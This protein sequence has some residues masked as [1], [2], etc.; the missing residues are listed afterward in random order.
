MRLVLALISV[1]NIF[2]KSIEQSIPIVS[3]SQKVCNTLF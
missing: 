3:Y 1:K 2:L